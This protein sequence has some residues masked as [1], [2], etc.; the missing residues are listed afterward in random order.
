MKRIAVFS[1]AV[2]FAAVVG[3]CSAEEKVTAEQVAALEASLFANL[4]TMDTSSDAKFAQELEASEGNDGAAKC[5]FWCWRRP[6]RYYYPCY[7][8][9]TWY[10]PVYYVPLRIVT[11]S[12]PVVTVQPVQT[13]QTQVVTPT[14]PAQTQASATAVASTGDATATATAS[15]VTK[16]LPSSGRVAKGAVIDATVPATSPLFKMGLR[17]G[18]I[19]TTVDGNAV[20]SLLDARR[21]KADSNITYVRGNQIKVAGKPILQGNSKSVQVSDGSKSNDVT[22]DSIKEIQ[23]SEMSLYEYYDSLEKAP[24]TQAA[25][26]QEYG[27]NEY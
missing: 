26:A 22:V 24:A 7:Y 8:Y 13:V 5:W 19:I 25:P 20:N 18:D 12:V 6:V 11:Y 14:Q 9:Y 27:A 21:I 3:V 15:V 10:C 16:F 2:V 17:S 23:K 1:L 4:E